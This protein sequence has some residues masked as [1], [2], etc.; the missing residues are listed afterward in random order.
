MLSKQIKYKKGYKY[1][2]AEDYTCHIDIHPEKDIITK[3]IILYTDGTL[4]ISE[5]YAWDGTSGPTLDG[6]TN[7]RG[8]IIHDAC[9]QLFREEHLSLKERKQADLEF[10]KACLE[11][12]M[13]RV[14]A[15]IDLVGLRKFGAFAASP[16]NETKILTAP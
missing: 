15:W 5:G 7:M 16:E 9:Y 1:L 14:R 11:D 12:G 6:K 13:C 10:Q 2:L 3:H 8:S 4:V